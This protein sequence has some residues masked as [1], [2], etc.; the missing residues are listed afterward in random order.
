MRMHLGAWKGKFNR[1]FRCESGGTGGAKCNGT[2]A[3]VCQKSRAER[4]FP[5]VGGELRSFRLS[6]VVAIEATPSCI[7][8][9]VRAILEALGRQIKEVIHYPVVKSSL[10]WT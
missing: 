3:G 9:G 7:D 6:V 1:T 5:T 10:C 4:F 2:E 8:H